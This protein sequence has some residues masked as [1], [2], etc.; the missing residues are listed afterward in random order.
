MD[1]LI[2]HL[3]VGAFRDPQ[4]LGDVDLGAHRIIVDLVKNISFLDPR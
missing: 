2:D 4:I 3:L 1:D